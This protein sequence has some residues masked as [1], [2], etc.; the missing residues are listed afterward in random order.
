MTGLKRKFDPP[1]PPSLPLSGE[2][3]QQK[4]DRGFKPFSLGRRVGSGGTSVQRIGAKCLEWLQQGKVWWGALAQA[5]PWGI[6]ATLVLL[7]LVLVGRDDNSSLWSASCLFWAA[8]ALILWQK[9]HHLPWRNDRSART[10]GTLLL[11][12]ILYKSLHVYEQ[13]AFL[14]LF[15]I[16]SL[17]SFSLLVSG[18]RG[19]GQYKKAF[20]L[21][22]FL[23]IPWQLLYLLNITALTTQFASFL[24]GLS[25]FAVQQQNFSI[26]LPGGAVEVYNGCSG[27]KSMVQLL[28]LAWIYLAYVPTR[29]WRRWG[30][31][32]AAVAIGFVGNG[33]R[34]ALMAVL[35]EQPGQEA[36]RYWHQGQGSLLFS[37]ASVLLFGWVI[38][39][40]RN[41]V[42]CDDGK[43]SKEGRRGKESKG[44]RGSKGGEGSREGK[45]RWELDGSDYE[46]FS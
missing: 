46:H 40:L 22:G 41:R 30:I 10:L 23:A 25:G 12:W 21:L 4:R 6:A 27:V 3:E 37:L 2:R 32:T 9:R 44:S 26:L 13:D 8:T 35:S 43:E 7:H 45:G 17:F 20:Q 39:G 1:H 24:L 15:P 36:L 11:A 18:W 34:V 14:R 19:I 31:L 42:P 5:S 16:L 29:G 28:G 33:A 38:S